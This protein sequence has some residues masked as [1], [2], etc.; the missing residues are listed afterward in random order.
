M[1]GVKSDAR[2]RAP[3]GGDTAFRALSSLA[4]HDPTPQASE[5]ARELLD[6]FEDWDRLVALAVHHRVGPVVLLNLERLGLP[7]PLTTRA[8]LRAHARGSQARAMFLSGELVL[9]RKSLAGRGIESVAL[10]GPPLGVRAHGTPVLRTMGDLDILIRPESAEAAVSVLRARG[11]QRAPRLDAAVLPFEH[12]KH[13]SRVELHSRL[14][15]P[16][17]PLFPYVEEVW[18]DRERV[19]LMGAPVDVLPLRLEAMY[20]AFHG[21][22]HRW[23]R[24]GW[25]AVLADLLQR[26]AQVLSPER[27][28]DDAARLRLNRIW[29]QTAT[30]L[31]ATWPEVFAAPKK[32]SVAESVTTIRAQWAAA[33]IPPSSPTT[34]PQRVVNA[35]A[36]IRY[37][38]GLADRAPDRTR[39]ALYGFGRLVRARIATKTRA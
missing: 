4:L 37:R 16:H 24:F 32:D 14:D 5:L 6:G 35:F 31:H 28:A 34:L 10:K 9:I 18:R 11:Y 19:E 12:P 22:M 38:A 33:A 7:L 29:R 25:L 36:A 8:T 30:L 15:K 3:Q 17:T 13:E 21:C 39:I 1:G 27:L 2:G 23:E 20:L 26:H